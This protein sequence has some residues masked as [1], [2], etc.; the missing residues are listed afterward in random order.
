MVA[1]MVFAVV[2]GRR[3]RTNRSFAHRMDDHEGV[4]NA[5]RAGTARRL[6]SEARTAASPEWAAIRRFLST[7]GYVRANLRAVRRRPVWALVGLFQPI[8]YLLLFGPLLGPPAGVPG[9]P[10]GGAWTVFTPGC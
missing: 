10:P 8:C 4:P 6:R 3:R 5:S 2:S 7:T 1:T 9:F